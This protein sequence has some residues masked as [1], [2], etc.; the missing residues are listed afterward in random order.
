MYRSKKEIFFAEA[1][2]S[3]DLK[4]ETNPS[5]VIGTPDIFFRDN[6]V[7]V[8]FNGCFWHSHGCKQ[9]NVN[10]EWKKRLTDIRAND[11]DVIE[12]LSE[13]GVVSLTVWEC[14]WERQKLKQV[15]RIRDFVALTINYGIKSR[16]SFSNSVTGIVA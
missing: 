6:G 12:K 15:D 9:H 16:K 13:V 1:L 8:F 5:D 3:Q 7:A 14:H 4:F 10:D 2:S 11:A